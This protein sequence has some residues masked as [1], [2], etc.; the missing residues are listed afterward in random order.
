MRS[1]D[2]RLSDGST[3]TV[4]WTERSDGDFAI[5]APAVERRRRA[6]VDRPW[7]WLRQVHGDRVV[8][9]DDDDASLACGIEADS[10]VSRRA[11]VALSVQSADCTTIGLWSDD[12]V[13][14]A[15]H[16][17]WRGLE[18]GV[19]DATMTA[20]R[21]LTTAP[22]HAVIGPSIGVECNEFGTDDLDRLQRR[23][24]DVVL[25]RTAA[26]AP[27][28][29]V[30]AGVR[31]SLDRLGIEIRSSDDRC[32]ACE[33]ESFHSHRARAEQGRQSLVVWR[34]W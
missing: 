1:V 34:D 25:G 18:A 11:D 26:G 27:A 21:S 6:L 16:C 24:G 4:A 23:F 28:L 13:I 12:G 7:F 20:M 33:A 9:V 19:V 29:D 2:D 8:V 5:D 14:A 22:V 15:V 3:V 31:S 32:T 17:G 10:I 30:R